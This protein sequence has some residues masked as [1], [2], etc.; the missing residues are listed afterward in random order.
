MNERRHV[1]LASRLQGAVLQQVWSGLYWWMSNHTQ[2]RIWQKLQAISDIAVIGQVATTVSNQV[3][4]QLVGQSSS[5]YYPP[6]KGN[7]DACP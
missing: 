1:T 2:N 3:Q 7:Y 5:V 6:R 4:E